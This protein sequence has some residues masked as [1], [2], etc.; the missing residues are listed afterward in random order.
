[1]NDALKDYLIS[2]GAEPLDPTSLKKYERKMEKEVIPRIVKAV[3]NRQRLA[4]E[5]KHRMAV[6]PSS[7]PS[8]KD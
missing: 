7:K 8:D 4:A 2:I 1:M 5:A 3:R 6:T